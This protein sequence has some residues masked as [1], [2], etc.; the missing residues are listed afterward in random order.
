[1]TTTRSEDSQWPPAAALRELARAPQ[2]EPRARIPRPPLAV[3]VTLAQ[4]E[5]RAVARAQQGMTPSSEAQEAPE[6]QEAQEAQR[7]QRE[8]REQRAQQGDPV[9]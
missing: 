2:D 7:E 4:P 3:E 9:G 8:Q 5:A 1:M 6:A